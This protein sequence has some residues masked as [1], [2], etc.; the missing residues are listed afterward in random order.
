MSGTPVRR[1]VIRGSGSALPETCVTNAE[2]ATRVDTT[3]E[4]I[5]ERTGIRARYIANES[6]TTSSLATLAAQRALDAAGIAATDIDLIILATATPDQT[7]PACATI[8][9]HNLGCN[10]GIAFDVAAVCSRW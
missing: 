4:W 8:V 2:L 5:V 3:D 10:G 6:E 9:Q 7:F 1:S